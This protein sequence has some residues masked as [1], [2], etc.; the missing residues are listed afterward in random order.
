VNKSVARPDD[1]VH[2]FFASS[3]RKIGQAV[4]DAPFTDSLRGLFKPGHRERR[5]NLPTLI[6]LGIYGAA[7]AS[8][9]S[10]KAILDHA[11]EAVEGKGRLPLRLRTLT[12]SGWT[13]A[14]DRLP[15]GLL[16]RFWRHW[17]E[18]AR[19]QAGTKALF[20][21]LRLVALDKKT[22]TVPEA[23]W[24]TFR[25]HR[26]GRGEGPAQAELMVAYDVAV[27]V[28][29]E[30][31][32]GRVR[33]NERRMAPRLLRKL[34]RPSLLLIDCGFYGLPLFAEA[35]AAGHHFLTK[36]AKSGCPKALERFTW[37]DGLFRITDNRSGQTMT[38]RIITTQ[39]RGWRPVR[40]VTS[41][42]D[43]EAFPR[44]EIIELYHERWHIETFFRELDGEL[45][46]QHW[47]TRKLRTLYVELLFTMIYVTVVR[48]HM[49]EA[50]ARKPTLPGHL[51]FGAS[52]D[53]S[54]RAWCRVPKC[55]PERVEPLRRELLEGLA[56]LPIDIRPGRLFERDTQKRR[57]ASRA[58]KLQA[59][60]VKELAA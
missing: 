17:V 33:E 32:L 31:T 43:P 42:L 2:S 59:L 14:K 23:L 9:A 35:R 54:M 51:R 46:F 45:T 37:K 15:L 13:R 7:H 47:H 8:L 57:A 4:L 16:K 44:K 24:T 40:L 5:F 36:M 25:S 50:V 48:A 58:R 10:M 28:P 11:C 22:I 49:A 26:G 12:Q 41:L 52:A 34:P 3:A 1:G 21:G 55:A 39:R 38:V 53:L 18:L 6:W 60:K 29:L 27:R 19:L 30:L 20:H 56:A